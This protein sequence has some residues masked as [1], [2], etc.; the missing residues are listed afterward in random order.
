MQ[1]ISTQGIE[2]KSSLCPIGSTPTPCVQV[3]IT[4]GIE[5]K[6]KAPNKKC[7]KAVERV[8]GLVL[9]AREPGWALPPGHAAHLDAASRVQ[10]LQGA[11]SSPQHVMRLAALSRIRRRG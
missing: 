7:K 5:V 10:Q 6:T 3:I 9:G 11:Y 2:V 1:V 8:R 4:Q